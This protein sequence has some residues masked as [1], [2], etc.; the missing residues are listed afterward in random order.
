MNGAGD[1]L[2]VRTEDL[3]RVIEEWI[4]KRV[5]RNRHVP[6]SEFLLSGNGYGSEGWEGAVGRGGDEHWDRQVTLYH[7]VREIL[8]KTG[9]DAE[10][11]RRIRKRVSK[12]T[13]FGTADRLLSAIERSDLLYS[14]VKV[15]P[16]PMWSREKWEGWRRE[17]KGGC[18]NTGIE[19]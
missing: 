11:L 19:F 1:P 18:E 3:A 10:Q 17:Q 8:E 6:G 7:P 14:V 16:N 5:Q 2:V 12:H 4:E 15:V 9:M 13:S